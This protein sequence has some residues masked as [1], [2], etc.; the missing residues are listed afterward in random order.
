MMRPQYS[1]AGDPILSSTLSIF[2][3]GFGIPPLMDGVLK[4]QLQ[5][6]LLVIRATVIDLHLEQDGHARQI[7]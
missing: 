7:A 3:G 1:M 6:L 5:S 4:M 2:P